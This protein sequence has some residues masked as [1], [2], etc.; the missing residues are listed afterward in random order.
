M[1]SSSRGTSTADARSRDVGRCSGEIAR[2]DKFDDYD[3]FRID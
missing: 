2:G 3:V 1:K